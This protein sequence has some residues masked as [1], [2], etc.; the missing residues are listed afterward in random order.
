MKK[1]L[2]YTLVLCLTSIHQFSILPTSAGP[3]S[4]NYELQ[5]Y[6]FG[7][8]GTDSNLNSANYGL[9]G[10]AGEVES[11]RPAS[12]GF[13]SGNGLVYLQQSGVPSAPTLTNPGGSNYNKLHLTINY[14]IS[15]NPL[16]PDLLFAIA[17]SPNFSNP[18]LTKY[19]QADHTLG[20]NPVWQSYSTWGDASGFDLIDLNPATTYYARVAAKQGSFTQTGFGEITSPGVAT[21]PL[22]LSLNIRTANQAVPPFSIGLGQLTPGSV[23]A[24]SD[25]GQVTISTNAY[26]GALI[27]IYGTNAGL[28]S[29]SQGNYTIGTVSSSGQDLSALS[30][31]YG[32]RATNVSQDSGNMTISEP[33]DGTGNYVGPADTNERIIFTT[34]DAPITNGIGL[35]EIQ[36]KA[37]ITTPPAS[38]YQDTLTIVAAGVF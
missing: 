12:D 20:D 4:T 28:K 21:V 13:Q 18:I 35:F 29:S 25:Q 6:Q 14:N 31:G 30:Q 17:V 36:A 32:I 8:A 3:S 26:S 38:D 33:F 5:N 9:F 10:I 37:S 2:I 16:P 27:Y 34:G 22:L 7:A 11:D 1:V 15:Y 23:V 19:V 24:A